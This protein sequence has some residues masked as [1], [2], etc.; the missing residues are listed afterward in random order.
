MRGLP[1]ERFTA[2]SVRTPE[3]VSRI[4]AAQIDAPRRIAWMWDPSKKPLEGRL[5]GGHFRVWPV[6]KF[7]RNGFGLCVIGEIEAQGTGSFIRAV[8]RFR[9]VGEVFWAIWMVVALA[10]ATS[11]LVQEFRAGQVD[12]W[13]GLF[14]AFPVLG[15]LWGMILFRVAARRVKRVLSEVARS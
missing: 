4:L 5:D 3:E 13:I 7:Q 1:F 9:L 12:G 14:V 10:M 6:T 8:I 11:L 15:Y 2:E